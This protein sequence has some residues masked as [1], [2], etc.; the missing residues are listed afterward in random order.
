MYFSQDLTRSLRN[1]I[2]VQSA[3]L[4]I[5]ATDN[6]EKERLYKFACQQLR[7]NT[8]KIDLKVYDEFP[9]RQIEIKLVIEKARKLQQ[10]LEEEGL[11]YK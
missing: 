4:T 9:E 7:L 6:N 2:S 3:I 5:E 10:R 11:C 1:L 8:D